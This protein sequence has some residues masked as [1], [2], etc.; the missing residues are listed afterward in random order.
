MREKVNTKLG[1]WLKLATPVM[2]K[3]LAERSRCSLSYLQILAGAHRENPRI[4]LAIAIVDAANA[5][6][7]ETL[8]GSTAA[9][10]NGEA[11]IALPVLTLTDMATPTR[12]V[13]EL[14][15]GL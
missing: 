15:D 1:Q 14:R 11:L 12:I 8:R 3:D 2:K 5:I 10:R 6:R 13:R 9:I 7:N 4:R